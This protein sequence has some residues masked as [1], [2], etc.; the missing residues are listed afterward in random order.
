MQS[1]RIF[2]LTIALVATACSS[3]GGGGGGANLDT[4]GGSDT[5]TGDVAAGPEAI[6]A[7]D[8]SG[9]GGVILPE[10]VTA[11]WLVDA[12]TDWCALQD[13]CGDGILDLEACAEDCVAAADDSE[14]LATVAC[15]ALGWEGEESDCG[16]LALCETPLNPEECVTFCSTMVECGLL[17][18]A[19]SEFFGTTEEECVLM[20]NG[21]ATLVPGGQFDAAVECLMPS[22]EDCDLAEMIT[23]LGDGGI[24]ESICGPEGA[25]E[26]CGLV[27]ELWPDEGACFE[28]CEAWEAGPAIAV[29]VCIESLLPGEDPDE[30]SPFGD[31][32]DCAEV[33]AARCMEPP[34]AL[35][36]G[37]TELCTALTDLCGDSDGFPSFP[38]LDICGWFVTGFL[39]TAPSGLFHDDFSAAADCVGDLEVCE[40]DGGAWLGCFLD[41]YPPAQ[42]ACE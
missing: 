2:V 1:R 18:E 13:A 36:E 23:C 16:L 32:G 6:L 12:C 8:T 33:A 19:T 3:G 35:A 15:A 41:V 5:V 11:E 38:S 26:E 40:E 9:E 24:C 29:Q 39:M 25:A 28:V 30:G 10:G 21:F 7:A 20:C 27:P 37:A 14:H 22:A 42:D 17:G 31:Q 4:T 34:A